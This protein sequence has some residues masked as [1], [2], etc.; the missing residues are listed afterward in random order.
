MPGMRFES[1]ELLPTTP[2]DDAMVGGIVVIPDPV[3]V[4]VEN[5]GTGG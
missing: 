1:D 2:E 3:P 4:E 5:S